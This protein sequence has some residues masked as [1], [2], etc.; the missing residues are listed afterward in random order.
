MIGQGARA[1][2]SIEPKKFEEMAPHI[3]DT[4][5]KK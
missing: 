4:M 3:I 2:Y 5:Q 1:V